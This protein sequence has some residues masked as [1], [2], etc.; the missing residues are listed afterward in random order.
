MSPMHD[1]RRDPGRFG[2][3]ALLAALAALTYL[4]RICIAQAAPAIRRELGLNDWQMGIVFSSFVLAYALF[5][6]PSGWLGDRL[7][8]KRVLVRVV[9]WWSAFTALTGSAVSFLPLVLIR[10]AFGAGE[11]GAFPNIAGALARRFPRHERGRAQGVIWTAARLGGAAAP[12]LTALLIERMG[13]RHTFYAYGFLGLVWTG[14]FVLLFRDEPADPKEHDAPGPPKGYVPWPVILGDRSVWALAGV[15]ACAAFGWY[16]YITWMPIYLKEVR[17]F[18]DAQAARVTSLALLFGVVGCAVGGVL[19]DLVASWTRGGSW[20][21]RAIGVPGALCAGACFLGGIASED[22]LTMTILLALAS[23]CND[24]T[25]SG[26]WAAMMDIG[27]RS[28]GRV[29]GV[30][31]TASGLGAFACPLVFGAF[32]ANSSGGRGWAPA[33]VLAGTALGL[34]GLFWMGVDPTRRAK[35]TPDPAEI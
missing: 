4:D 19:T 17:G 10:F 2:T 18:T 25:M 32:L 24:V 3:L 14:V 16:F 26:L 9:L 20:S 15:T 5:E 22:A 29:A 28:S 11:A 23:F 1:P 34:A 6:I 21:R 8:P 13:W 30:V 7:G 33:L 35:P 31:N 27:E 12:I